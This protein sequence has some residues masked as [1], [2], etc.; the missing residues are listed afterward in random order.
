MILKKKNF[1]TVNNTVEMIVKD[2]GPD[3]PEDLRYKYNI[4]KFAYAYG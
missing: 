1:I 2:E 3:L 4:T